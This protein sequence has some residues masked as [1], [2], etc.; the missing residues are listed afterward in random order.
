[1][2]M[3]TESDVQIVQVNSSSIMQVRKMWRMVREMECVCEMGMVG[4]NG[5]DYGRWGM[6]GLGIHLAYLGRWGCW[7]VVCAMGT[8][9]TVYMSGRWILMCTRWYGVGT[10]HSL[11]LPLSFISSRYS[12]GTIGGITNYWDHV[13]R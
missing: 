12:F 9:D 2:G 13:G 8:F 3:Y 11:V 7:G 6:C 10:A 4:Q 5:N 1:M